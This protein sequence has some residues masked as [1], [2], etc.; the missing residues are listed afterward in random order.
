MR[1]TVSIASLCATL[2]F[3]LA[4]GSRSA[5]AASTAAEGPRSTLS[6]HPIGTTLLNL[7]D[8]HFLQFTY[9]YHPGPGR[10]SW[11]WDPSVLFIDRSEKDNPQSVSLWVIPIVAPRWYFRPDAQGWFGGAKL[12]YIHYLSL[13]DERPP[14]YSVRTKYRD[15]SELGYLAGEYG[16]KRD[17]KSVSFYASGQLGLTLGMG[18]NEY[19]EG[20]RPTERSVGAAATP[21]GQINCGLGYRF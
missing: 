3:C 11:A 6:I 5:L 13:N 16:F 14:A 8:N 12:G 21:F 7:P 20:S 10:L 1:R 2:S 19:T 15:R 17:W 9:E 18:S 4:F